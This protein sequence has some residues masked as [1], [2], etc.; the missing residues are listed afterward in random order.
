MKHIGWCL[1]KIQVAMRKIPR[2][3]NNDKDKE[4]ANEI[5]DEVQEYTS[6]LSDLIHNRKFRRYIER[7][8]NSSIK[9]VRLEEQEVEN[10]AKDLEHV[11]SVI[12]SY[13]NELRVLIT[14]HSNSWL[15]KGKQIII[16][17]INLLDKKKSK[18]GKEWSMIENYKSLIKKRMHQFNN[19]AD[20]ITLAIDQKFG[21]ERGELRKEFQE[22]IYTN[23]EL[24]EIVKSEEH[25]A[26][27]LK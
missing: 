6:T 18:L 21:G 20:Q 13:I 24:K 9:D 26:E 22:I 17:T 1:E 12:D 14:N 27:F 23:E 5:L 7:L 2:R 11:I 16:A 3:L 10:F 8:R 4:K 25:L 15:Y 19:K